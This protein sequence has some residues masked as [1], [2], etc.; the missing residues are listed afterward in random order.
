MNSLRLFVWAW[1]TIVHRVHTV[2]G[3]KNATPE[4]VQYALLQ[5]VNLLKIDEQV[6]HHCGASMRSDAGLLFPSKNIS[7]PLDFPRG[8]KRIGRMNVS[9]VLPR[10]VFDAECARIRAQVASHEESVRIKVLDLLLSKFKRQLNAFLHGTDEMTY[11]LL[12]LRESVNLTDVVVIPYFYEPLIATLGHIYAN[13]MNTGKWTTTADGFSKLNHTVTTMCLYRSCTENFRNLLG[14]FEKLTFLFSANIRNR[15]IG[16]HVDKAQLWALFGAPALRGLLYS[17]PQDLVRC[18]Q[19]VNASRTWYDT[20]T[21]NDPDPQACVAGSLPDTPMPQGVP[22]ET[23][24]SGQPGVPLSDGC[25]QDSHCFEL[26]SVCNVTTRVC[27]SSNKFACLANSD[28]QG[29]AIC[30]EGICVDSDAWNFTKYAGVD[31]QIA[32]E[33]AKVSLGPDLLKVDFTFANVWMGLYDEHAVDYLFGHPI[34]QDVFKRDNDIKRKHDYLKNAYGILEKQN[35]TSK[36]FDLDVEIRDELLRSHVDVDEFAMKK[37][38][39]CSDKIFLHSL[40]K[41]HSHAAMYDRVVDCAATLTYAKMSC[42]RNLK[43]FAVWQN[44]DNRVLG[45]ADRVTDGVEKTL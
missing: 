36:S 30:R 22:L 20:F 21:I 41:T 3:L 25:L 15:A 11:A 40:A 9:L 18:K 12:R 13:A 17:S 6:E 28:C 16:T 2:H 42:Y 37:E 34:I 1:L 29:T 5:K 24:P 33:A 4:V 45:A 35:L 32:A 19:R 43:S 39:E 38:R 7:L 31:K 10:I 8:S 27:S 14:V 26:G 23:W 44:D